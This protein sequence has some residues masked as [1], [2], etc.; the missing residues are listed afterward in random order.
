VNVTDSPSSNSR[1]SFSTACRQD[2]LRTSDRRT[3]NEN[4]TESH[5]GDLVI[6]DLGS[7]TE[8]LVHD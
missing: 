8:P 4:P 7:S 3:K 1:K 6:I 2:V 5:Y